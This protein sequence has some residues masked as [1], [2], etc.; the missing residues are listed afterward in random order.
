MY[1][2]E[3]NNSEVCNAVV[4]LVQKLQQDHSERIQSNLEFMRMYG[5]KTTHN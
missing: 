5:Q 4:D 1:W 2:Y 3:H